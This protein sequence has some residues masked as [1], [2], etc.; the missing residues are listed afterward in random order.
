[1]IKNYLAYIQ[2]AKVFTTD[3]NAPTVAY[4]TAYGK[5]APFLTGRYF[6][7][8][9]SRLWRGISVDEHLQNKWLNDLSDIKDIEMRSS[10]EGHTPERVTF[11][12]FRLTDSKKSTDK[13][14]LDTLIKNLEKSDKL[15][16]ASWSTGRGEKRTRIVVTA[17]LWYGQ[18]G[19]KEWWNSLAKRVKRCL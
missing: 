6:G 4:E 18:P 1:M 8:H 13:K 2:E 12:I 10:C 17:I 3:G 11:I 5:K 14:Y 15:T 9:E 16:K 7:D 19:W